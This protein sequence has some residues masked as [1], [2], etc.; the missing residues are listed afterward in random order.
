MLK[1]VSVLLRH[2]D[3]AYECI[4]FR[5]GDRPAEGAAC[6]LGNNDAGTLGLMLAGGVAA[7]ENVLVTFGERARVRVIGTVN[8]EAIH[9]RVADAAFVLLVGLD[10]GRIGLRVR[11]G[12]IMKQSRLQLVRSGRDV[13][14]QLTHA[15]R[16]IVGGDRKGFDLLAVQPKGDQF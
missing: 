9:V 14:P 2:V 15:R 13:Q 8:L 11:A 10:V 5:T 6:E 12:I 7:D 4:N 3:E 16:F 1:G